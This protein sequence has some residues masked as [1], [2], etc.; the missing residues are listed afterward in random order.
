MKKIFGFL[1]LAILMNG[2]RKPIYACFVY[3]PTAPITTTTALSFDASCSEE[4][5]T[6]QWNYNDGNVP[7]P[8]S[9]SIIDSHTFLS[10]GTYSVTLTV[11]RS[12]R[13]KETITTT[14]IIIV[15]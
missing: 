1:L 10:Q 5:E 12:G 2:C 15:Q 6:F 4:A 9:S 14:Q 8:Q 7:A 13:K 11:G 3:S